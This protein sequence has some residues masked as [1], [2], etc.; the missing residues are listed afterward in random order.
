LIC[1]ISQFLFSLLLFLQHE[2]FLNLSTRTDFL[3][4]LSFRNI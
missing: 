3:L 4:R 2:T 1:Q